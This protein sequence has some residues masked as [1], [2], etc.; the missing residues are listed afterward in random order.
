MCVCVRERE[1]E[2]ERVRRESELDSN[3]LIHPRCTTHKVLT[4]WLT[5]SCQICG[6][7]ESTSVLHSSLRAASAEQSSSTAALASDYRQSQKRNNNYLFTKEVTY[8]LQKFLSLKFFCLA[9]IID[10]IF[11]SKNC[12]LVTASVWTHV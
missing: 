8:I 1:N 11:L 9:Q 10:E 3:S 12:L 7:Y 4:A 2:K 5:S 6:K